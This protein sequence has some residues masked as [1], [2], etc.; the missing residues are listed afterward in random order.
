MFGM[1]VIG[2]GADYQLT[3]GIRGSHDQSV[4]RG[5]ALG[6]NVLVCSNL[7]F[8]GELFT[9]KVKQ[10]T[11]ASDRIYNMIDEGVGAIPDAIRT[12]NEIFDEYKQRKLSKSHADQLILNAFRRHALTGSQLAVAIKEYDNPSYPEHRENG[13]LWKLFNAFTQALKP[14]GE[15]ANMNTV[16][17]RT[18]IITKMLNEYLGR[19]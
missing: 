11:H 3:L 17:Q 8:S 10:T 4:P 15:H 2:N 14:S 12:Q 16:M 6:T 1:M 13:E 9:G 5:M 19:G 7:C 18:Q